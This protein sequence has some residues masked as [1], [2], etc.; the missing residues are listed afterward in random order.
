MNVGMRAVAF[1][2]CCAL[3]VVLTACG[4]RAESESLDAD[5]GGA[6]VPMP[7]SMDYSGLDLPPS[8]VR[9]PPFADASTPPEDAIAAMDAAW[10][11]AWGFPSDAIWMNAWDGEADTFVLYVDPAAAGAARDAADASGTPQYF[12]VVPLAQDADVL[13]TLPGVTTAAEFVDLAWIAADRGMTIAE[14][15]AAW[16]GQNQFAEFL[17]EVEGELGAGLVEARWEDG[18][19]VLMVSAEAEGQALALAESAP[20]AV[21]VEVSTAE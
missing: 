12:E 7:R 3:A 8:D 14:A 4:A 18:Q 6:G 9:L 1:A 17:A 5:G 2:S 10:E 15:V 21:R 20:I 11:A 13:P 16:G 19:G